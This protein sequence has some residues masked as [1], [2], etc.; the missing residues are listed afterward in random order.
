MMRVKLSKVFWL[1]KI[2]LNNIL[3]LAKEE[4]EDSDDSDDDHGLALIE[5]AINPAQLSAHD[6]SLI[7][8]KAMDLQLFHN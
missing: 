1:I 5:E 3:K 7:D 8:N 6:K 4:E 2:F